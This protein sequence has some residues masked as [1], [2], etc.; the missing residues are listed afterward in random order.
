V[1]T[2]CSVAAEFTKPGGIGEKLHKLLQERAAASKT[3]WLEG[4]SCALRGSN[5]LAWWDS[6][7]YFEPRYP[8]VINVNYYFHYDIYQPGQTSQTKRAANLISGALE[9]KRLLET[10]VLH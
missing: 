3:H 5:C 9:F 7:G 8:I 10:F 1:L 4:L 6:W 2:L